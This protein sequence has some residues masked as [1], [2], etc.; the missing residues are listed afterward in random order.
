M[1]KSKITILG[2]Y[3]ERLGRTGKREVGINVEREQQQQQQQ[4]QQQQKQQQHG[5]SPRRVLLSCWNYWTCLLGLV[6]STGYIRCFL[7]QNMAAAAAVAACMCVFANGFGIESIP[8]S[9]A[10]VVV[11]V[12]ASSDLPTTKGR[13]DVKR[14]E[15][16]ERKVLS[17]DDFNDTLAGVLLKFT[18]IPVKE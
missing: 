17:M 2:N 18:R 16:E 12:V 7:P 8:K 5:W 11:V 6:G 14:V 1:V 4:K 3:F 15:S 10:A 9:L 13:K